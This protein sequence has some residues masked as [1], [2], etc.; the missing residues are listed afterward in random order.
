MPSFRYSCFISYSHG[1][2]DLVRGFVEQFK[3]ALKGELEPLVDRPLFIDEGLRAG[4]LWERELAIALCE[5]VC[6][7]VIYSPVYERRPYCGREFEAM[8]QLEQRR[9]QLL[10]INSPPLG[11]I[12]PVVLRGFKQLPPR[13]AQQRQALDF[14]HFTLAD[15]QMKRNPGF[16]PRIREVAERIQAHFLTLEALEAQACE[17][18][19]QFSLPPADQVQPWRG[20]S[21][22]PWQPVFPNR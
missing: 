13:I 17:D 2:E 12:I 11:L 16:A 8:V 1:E 21:V 5:S 9:R 22:T 7:V 10:P 15:E 18:C 4:D 20:P 19:G 3:A 6:M 14:S